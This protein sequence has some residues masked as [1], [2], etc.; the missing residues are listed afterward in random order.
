MDAYV[1][2]VLQIQI[3]GIHRAGFGTFTATDT[4]ILFVNNP[5]TILATFHGSCRADLG[6]WCRR[7]AQTNLGDKAGGKSA[8]R[9]YPYPCGIP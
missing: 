1:R 4:Y 7:A 9:S 5:A 2:A 3:N 6:T 8:G